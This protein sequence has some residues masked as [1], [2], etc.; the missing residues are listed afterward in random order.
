MLII[1]PNL[2]IDRTMAVDLVVP[3]AVHRTGT[4]TI[5]LGG[6]GVNVARVARAFGHRGV[7]VGFLPFDS[8]ATLDHLAA[9]EGAELSGVPVPGTVRSATIMLETSGRVS[10]FN[11]P[12]PT[13]DEPDWQRMLDEVSRQAA[14]HATVVCS[15][16]LPPGSPVDAYARVVATARRAGLRSV[17]DTTGDALASALSE[18]PDVVSPNLAEAESLVSGPAIEGVEPSGENVAERAA[19]AAHGLVARGARRAIVSAGSRGAA[20]S[21]GADTVFCPAPEVAV[22]SPIGAGD[23]F[24]GGLVLA[25]E[26]DRPWELA[27]SFGLAV[28]SASC[29]QLTAGTVDPARARELATTLGTRAMSPVPAMSPGADRGRA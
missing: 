29:E 3:G 26:E 16:S 14:G 8:A 18:H 23:A 6:K 13:V 19:E 11:E 24:V 1:N 10:V 21:D 25:L 17:V 22:I 4:A 5:T 28:A 2:T 15:G 20:F 12:G 27:A 7:L 9:G